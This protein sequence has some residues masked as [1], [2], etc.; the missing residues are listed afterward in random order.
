MKVCAFSEYITDAGPL[1]AA[2]LQYSNKK[3]RAYRSLVTSRWTT[4]VNKQAWYLRWFV[5]VVL[6]DSRFFSSTLLWGVSSSTGASSSASNSLIKSIRPFTPPS[7]FGPNLCPFPKFLI[8]HFKFKL[9]ENQQFGKLITP[10]PFE[11]RCNSSQFLAQFLDWSWASRKIS[12]FSLTLSL[13]ID[14]LLVSLSRRRKN[15]SPVY[16]RFLE[17]ETIPT[18]NSY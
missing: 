18:S 2:N 16:L 3:E 1:L 6:V 5:L 14:K 13:A 4:Q 11:C 17:N 9:R 15:W 7:N 10:F 12:S 8:D